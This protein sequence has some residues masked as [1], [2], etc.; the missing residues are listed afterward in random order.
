MINWNK[1]YTNR[2]DFRPIS[3]RDID[4]LL[5]CVSL[6]GNIHSLDIGCGT[7]HLTRELWHRGFMPIGID[8]SESAIELAK[9]Y[10]V[11]SNSEI[12]YRV[13]NLETQASSELTTETFSLITCKLVYAFI[14]DKTFFLKNASQL[15]AKDGVFVVITPLKSQVMREKAHIAVEY[16]ETLQELSIFFDVETKKDEKQVM[17]ICRKIEHAHADN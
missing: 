13:F 2:T 1:V 17:F 12:K 9:S 5:R 8:I 4:T 14:N 6:S 10:T 11:L 16:E 15:L 7:G 3:Q